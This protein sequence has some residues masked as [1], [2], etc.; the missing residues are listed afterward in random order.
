MR[1]WSCL[2]ALALWSGVACSQTALGQPPTQ[3]DGAAALTYVWRLDARA[4]QYFWQGTR[5]HPD[6]YLEVAVDVPYLDLISQLRPRASPVLSSSSAAT[7]AASDPDALFEESPTRK[8]FFFDR[9]THPAMVTVWRFSEDGAK[10]CVAGEFIN[11]TVLGNRATLSLAKAPIRSAK[12]LWKLVWFSP[13]LDV[14][15]EFYAED[16]VVDG[17]PTRSRDQIVRLAEQVSSLQLV[18][19]SSRLS[20][21]SGRR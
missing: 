7:A 18:G 11:A 3:C 8:S 1:S 5:R 20:K 16:Q 2:G 12:C 15:F 19:A 17:K 10:L 4:R 13:E 6:G 9:A 21:P 14:Q